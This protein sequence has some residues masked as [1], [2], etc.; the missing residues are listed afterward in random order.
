[1]N[2]SSM[3]REW[4]QEQDQDEMW[5]KQQEEELRR[6]EEE[7]N[8]PIVYKEF[9]E[10]FIGFGVQFDQKVAIYDYARCVDILEKGGMMNSQ[11]IDYME[12]TVLWEY[13]GR[14]TAV[15]LTQPK[16]GKARVKKTTLA[17][18]T[19]FDFGGES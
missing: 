12:N 1:M 9:N 14:R 11:A 8:D 16:K 10:A 4:W 17:G 3:P 15:F 13:A 2:E 19:S 18:Q 7:S 5:V 6:H